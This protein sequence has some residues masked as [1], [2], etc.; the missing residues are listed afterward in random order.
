MTINQAYTVLMAKI[1]TRLTLFSAPNT[2]SGLLH[3]AGTASSPPPHT[4]HPDDQALSLR[5][6]SSNTQQSH[7]LP[8]QHPNSPIEH[9]FPCCRPTALSLLEAS[10]C[11]KSCT[12]SL[13]SS[14]APNTSSLT[15]PYPSN[16][17]Y[18]WPSSPSATPP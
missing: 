5:P 15:S 2:Q 1:G 4:P 10:I 13:A 9:S 7:H 16:F 12:P 14:N 3:T 17:L 8:H 11:T 6:D 18:T